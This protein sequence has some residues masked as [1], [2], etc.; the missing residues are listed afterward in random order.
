MVSNPSSNVD[1]RPSPRA[2]SMRIARWVLASLVVIPLVAWLG[3]TVGV[4]LTVAKEAPFAQL[5]GLVGRGLF[6][7]VSCALG[8]CEAELIEGMTIATFDDHLTQGVLVAL[9]VDERGRVLLAESHRLN[10]GVEDNRRHDWLDA[11]LASRTIEDRSAYYHDA[12]ARGAVADA[13]YFTRESDRLVAIEDVDGDGVADRRSELGSW[14]EELTGNIAGVEAR[15][16]TI[17]VANIPSVYRILDEDGDGVAEQDKE[18][19]RGFGVKTSLGGH[20]L[21]GFAWGP[22][23][24][25][26]FSIGDRG[27]HLTLPDGRVLESPLGPG[28]GAVFRMNPDG[29]DFEV[30]ATGLRNPQELA[31]DDHGNLFTGDNNGDG[32]DPAR[33]VYVV[34]GGETGWAMPYQSL[35][36]DYVR[37][38]WMAERLFDLQHETQP[39][40]ILPPVAQIANGPSGFVH[41]P[42]LG[43]SERYANHFF[44][45]DYAYV[46]GQS[47]IWSFA[48]EPRGAGFEMV[49]RHPF[50]WSILTPDFDFSWDGRMFAARYDQLGD[51]RGIAVFEHPASRS[52]PRVAELSRI[53]ASKMATHT[54]EELIDWLAFPDQRIRLRAQFE[55]ARRR[56]IV[57]LAALAR[58]AKAAEIPRLHALWALGQIGADGVRALAPMS[59]WLDS[60]PEEIRAQLA[61]V[62]GDAGVSEGA[63]MLRGWLSDSSLRVRFFAAEALGE[64][65]D[66]ASVAPLFSV[67]RENADRDV[68][69]RHAAVLALHRIGDRE[70]V[71][72]HR[73]DESRSVRLAALLV[74][75]HAGDPRIASFLTDADPL[76]VVEA[77]RAIYDGPID[78]AMPALAALAGGLHP[79]ASDDRQVGQ[80]LHR[81]VIGANVR[82]RSRVGATALA[83]YAADES[84]LESLRELALEQLGRYAVP[85]VRDLTM[86]FYRPLAPVDRELVAT[87]LQAEGRA[88]VESSLGSRALE[89]A[90][91]YG[92]SPLSDAELIARVESGDTD[93][94]ERVAALAAL[95]ARAERLRAESARSNPGETIGDSAALKGAL[96]TSFRRAAERGIEDPAADVRSA[97]RELLTALDPEAGLESD[98]AAVARGEDPRERRAA[99]RRLGAIPDARARDA[100]GEGLAAWQSGELPDELALDV[101]EA[102]LAQ[103]DA[104]LAER[105]RKFLDA[106]RSAQVEG[107]R[108]ALAGGDPVAGRSVFQTVGDCQRCHGDPEESAETAG[109]G[110]RIGPALGGVAG[111]GAA[112][113][114]ESVLVPGAR[115]AEGFASPSAMPPIGLAL[116]PRDLRDLV[117]YLMTLD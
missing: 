63:P 57:P 50:I 2:R 73:A 89:I 75:R 64:L 70:A 109:H 53:A 21:H 19:Q 54:R 51:S 85:E 103:G 23:G 58:D 14:N 47:G 20:D 83:R 112:Y 12:I 46:Y 97:G 48:L 69:L 104:G 101:I 80:A 100:I 25:L 28:R 66:R 55:L 84:Q 78:E 43:L 9:D 87:V 8:G 106:S 5:L 86:G 44:L 37:G 82:L 91:E 111:K 6:G 76:L 98:L 1:S 31:F 42:G 38:P 96:A 11:D 56:E 74:L 77:A 68:F 27:Y 105:A 94:R 13:D 115:I 61:R 117:A 59:A 65:V 26:Y 15:E 39:A 24:K 30:F 93:L 95:R 102:G 67:L 88:L 49:D 34:E 17:W 4:K 45:C 90:G 36:G 113:A 32:G 92:V 60:A 116:A 10:A 99:W 81:R 41:Y 79:A 3:I 72:A 29:S 107:R 71:F 62:A 22:D 110:G 18:L 35:S 114:L 40:R 33:L 108:W 16:G 7:S 52:D